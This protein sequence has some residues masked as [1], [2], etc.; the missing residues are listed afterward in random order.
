MYMSDVLTAPAS[1]AGIPA[2]SIP[3]GRTRDGRPIG[4]QMMAPAFGETGLLVAARQV[5]RLLGAGDAGH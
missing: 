5:E 1:L 4:L 2:I 3:C